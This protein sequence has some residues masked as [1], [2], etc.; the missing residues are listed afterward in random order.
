[1]PFTKL[2]LAP[3]LLRAIEEAG[4]TKPSPIQ[5]GAIP[6]V[7]G[8]KDLLAGAQ[9]GTGKTAAFA[10]PVLHILSRKSKQMGHSVRVP[11]AL[12][13]TP[14][15][16]LAAQVCDSFVSYGKHLSL[17]AVPIFGGVSINP[18][19]KQF[20]KGV[21]IVVATPG[22]LLDHV[23]Q[24]TVNLQHIEILI[25]DEADRMLDMGFIR[26]IRKIMSR[27]PKKRQNLLFSATYTDEV[28]KLAD[29]ILN[30]PS[31]VEVARRSTAAESVTQKVYYCDKDSKRELLADL[32]EEG[33]WYQVLVFARTKHGSDRLAKQLRGFGIEAD[34]IHGNKSQNARTRTLATFKSGDLRVLV[35]TDIAA[36]G[37]DIENLPY[38]LNYELP[39]VAEDYVHRI[40]RTGRAGEKGIAISLVAPEERKF[41]KSIEKLLQKTLEVQETP[42]HYNKEPAIPEKERK[43][44]PR[45]RRS[46]HSASERTGKKDPSNP[47]SQS[48]KRY[49][50]GPKK[51]EKR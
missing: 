31:V 23:N 30:N 7:L 48:K 38:V 40:G 42:A 24:G 21:D 13:L 32:I 50:S 6:V 34:A 17:S 2:G 9:T 10:L 12:V 29:D 18:Q 37:I 15:R 20:R 14:T 19:I 1:M 41:L 33:Q 5:E 39:N 8:K 4:Y 16:E 43:P 22:R 49:R 36:R 51:A 25:L 3:E 46:H 47:G 44:A 11:S 35:A 45:S 28:R 26:D 27:L